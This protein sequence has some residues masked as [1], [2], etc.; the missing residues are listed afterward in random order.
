MATPAPPKI[1]VKPDSKPDAASAASSTPVPAPKVKV[2]LSPHTRAT[3]VAKR[4]EELVQEQLLD[5][6]LLA[7]IEA[8]AQAAAKRRLEKRRQGLA[9]APR[10]L[11]AYQRAAAQQDRV[12]RLQ[13]AQNQ[14]RS[15]S[16]MRAGAREPTDATRSGAYSPIQRHGCG[17]GCVGCNN[18]QRPGC[19]NTCNQ[20]VCVCVR[21]DPVPCARRW[22]IPATCV[23]TCTP[24]SWSGC[25]TGYYYGGAG[26]ACGLD[27][28]PVGYG[29][30]L[31]VDRPGWGYDTGC[32]VPLGVPYGCSYDPY[33]RSTTCR[34]PVVTTTPVAPFATLTSVGTA[35]TTFPGDRCPV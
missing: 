23:T 27:R 34:T 3:L 28:Y 14:Q 17:G 35:T 19:C 6:E 4:V 16:D 10:A 5:E 13:K 31:I 18:S 15:V 33:N 11:T 26:G 9:P 24:G 30:G 2:T 29:N 25:G 7:S 8:E 22:D 12:E 1:D 32:A 21:V 20:D